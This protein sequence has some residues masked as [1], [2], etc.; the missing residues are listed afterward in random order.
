MSATA[1]TPVAIA[2]VLERLTY[3]YR[4][5]CTRLDEPADL[6]LLALADECVAEL[7]R[8]PTIGELAE[9]C[10]V[11]SCVGEQALRKLGRLNAARN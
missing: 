2:E 9:M 5:Q 7:L 8:P 11:G 4:Q 3:L 10:A 6:G 1:L